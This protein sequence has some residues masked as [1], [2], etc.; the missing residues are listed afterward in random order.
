MLRTTFIALGFALAFLLFATRT[1]AQGETTSAI[2]GQVTDATGASVPD[3]TA[4]ITNHET[5]LRRSL[6]TDEEGR[7]N[8]PQLKPGTYSVKVDATGRH[9]WSHDGNQFQGE[10]SHAHR[11]CSFRDRQH[12]A[13]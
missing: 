11:A 1:P 13:S 7:F 3:A 12:Q 8:F 10:Q 2:V 5:G 6:K 4:T 9:R